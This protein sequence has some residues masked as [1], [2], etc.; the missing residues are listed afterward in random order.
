MGGVRVIGLLCD[1]VDFDGGRVCRGERSA[2]PAVTAKDNQ[3]TRG[4][5]DSCM[6]PAPS[7]LSA[8]RK[9]G[10][11]DG[12]LADTGS[13]LLITARDLCHVPS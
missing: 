9:C 13:C 12:V 7:T 6:A 4:R 8:I 5:N 11:D 10:L 3:R 2:F 1:E